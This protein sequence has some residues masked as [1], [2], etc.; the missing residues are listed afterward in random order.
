M[1]Q[2]FVLY[3]PQ[4]CSTRD[5]LGRFW[6][7]NQIGNPTA[8]CGTA[9]LSG[10]KAVRVCFSHMD[11]EEEDKLCSRSMSLR[12]WNHLNG[13]SRYET[14]AFGSGLTFSR[15][16]FQTCS[17]VL[18][19]LSQTTPSNPTLLLEYFLREPI[20]RRLSPAC[21]RRKTRRSALIVVILAFLRTLH[22]QFIHL[23]AQTAMR[24]NAKAD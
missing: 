17:T 16:Y 24:K 4:Y 12:L 18:F 13:R 20:L 8:L 2:H 21:E 5:N 22:S 23:Q 19:P 14:T 7:R 1:R 10:E 3:N 6:N 11:L 15:F 9:L